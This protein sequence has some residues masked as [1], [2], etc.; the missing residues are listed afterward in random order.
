MIANYIIKR[1]NVYRDYE[2]EIVLNINGKEAARA[3]VDDVRSVEDQSPRI[4]S[5]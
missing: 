2:L 4:V 3:L 5:D 1:V